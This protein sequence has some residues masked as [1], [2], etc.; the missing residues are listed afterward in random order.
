MIGQPIDAPLPKLGGRPSAAPST[1]PTPPT[2]AADVEKT[3]IGQPMEAPLP[4]LGGQPP[5]PPATP[6]TPDN[7]ATVAMEQPQAKPES[8]IL[9]VESSGKTYKLKQGDNKIGRTIDCN[10]AIEEPSMSRHHAS[11]TL[12]PQ[13]LT[14]SDNGSKNQTFVNN[15]PISTSVSI[16]T[17]SEVKFGDVVVKILKA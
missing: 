9:K 11:I 5:T 16:D 6:P 15:N 7:D 12:G 2:P 1:P 10:V 4:K 3:M 17:D 14:I 13:G 8:F